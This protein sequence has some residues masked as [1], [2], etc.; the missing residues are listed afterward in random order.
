MG[1]MD[2]DRIRHGITVLSASPKR[3]SCKGEGAVQ[4]S[5]AANSFDA[6]CS[7]Y[8]LRIVGHR[9]CLIELNGSLDHLP[10]KSGDLL[11]PASLSCSALQPFVGSSKRCPKS[12]H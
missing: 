5:L 10:Q 8:V 12:R 3:L 2:R 1:L 7:R 9:R 11:P 4:F 6:P